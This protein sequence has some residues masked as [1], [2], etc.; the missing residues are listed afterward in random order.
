MS[1]EQAAALVIGGLS[2]VAAVVMIRREVR[3]RLVF[4]AGPVLGRLRR[5]ECYTRDT[6]A[7]DPACDFAADCRRAEADDQ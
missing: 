4:E 5:T 2:I 6:C 1:G 3:H 7:L